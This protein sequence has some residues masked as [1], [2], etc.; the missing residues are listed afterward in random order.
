MVIKRIETK[1]NILKNLRIV[2]LKK[3]QKNSN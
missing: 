1:S 3:N 2:K